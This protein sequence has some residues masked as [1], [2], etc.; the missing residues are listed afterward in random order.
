MKESTI[1][2]FGII[3]LILGMTGFIYGLL[4][5]VQTAKLSKDQLRRGRRSG[6][7]TN[8]Y[9][10][11]E[12]PTL[13]KPISGSMRGED[14]TGAGETGYI[15]GRFSEPV[16]L[17]GTE[18]VVDSTL[19]KEFSRPVIRGSE[20]GFHQPSDAERPIARNRRREEEEL[21][22]Q[23][24][25]GH[26]LEEEGRRKA[27]IEKDELRKFDEAAEEERRRK[28]GPEGQSPGQRGRTTPVTVETG[29]ANL[30]PEVAEEIMA[31][32]SGTGEVEVGEFLQEDVVDD[33]SV[34]LES[35]VIG[36]LPAEIRRYLEQHGIIFPGSSD[37]GKFLFDTPHS[38]EIREYLKQHGVVPR[39]SE[40]LL[41]P[42]DVEER[43]P[44]SLAY[45]TI[46]DL[47]ERV[48]KFIKVKRGRKNR[49]LLIPF[50]QEGLCALQS[51]IQQNLRKVDNEVDEVFE[52]WR[53]SFDR[54]KAEIQNSTFEYLREHLSG[55]DIKNPRAY[56][57]IIDE[58]MRSDSTSVDDIRGFH[59]AAGG[60]G[61]VRGVVGYRQFS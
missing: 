46:E 61:S 26:H 16:A 31:A 14:I 54:V 56:H 53:G 2:T 4:A 29:E 22:R 21:I 28:I 13:D 57:A 11:D 3:G 23:V 12:E 8:F 34:S 51:D 36:D 5:F 15:G 50:Y 35:M 41:Q 19:D 37:I 59:E 10:A 55:L 47:V 7:I 17:G 33:V 30:T 32:K 9:I 25:I 52:F 6:N 40:S 48:S 49:D 44:T 24:D 42:D 38:P 39:D 60:Y 20:A 58:A 27:Q 18:R 45:G 43:P 1:E